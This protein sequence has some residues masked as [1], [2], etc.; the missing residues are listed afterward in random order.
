V[1]IGERVT[2][3]GLLGIGL[4]VLGIY[5]LHLKSFERRALLAPF[6]ALKERATQFALL[7]GICT[8]IYSTID[9]RGVTYANPVVYTTLIFWGYSA[10]LAPF[11][12]RKR[13]AVVQEWR[14]G[15]WRIIAVGV[16]STITYLLVTYVLRTS[17]ASYVSALR[18]ISIVLGAIL[19]AAFLNERLTP[20]KT[21]GAVVIFAGMICIGLAK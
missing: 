17:P 20:M 6:A 1:L 16:L 2:A 14:I 7:A 3:L 13:I 19:G 15:K 21:L 10:L 12:L 11:M 9:K 18:G 4:S 8:A 5:V